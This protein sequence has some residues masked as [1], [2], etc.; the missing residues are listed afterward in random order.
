MHMHM[1]IPKLRKH[2]PKKRVR[3]VTRGGGSRSQLASLCMLDPPVQEEQLCMLDP[4][5]QRNRF[6]P[7]LALPSKSAWFLGCHPKLRAHM[8]P[9]KRAR[10]AA[11]S[12]SSSSDPATATPK[13]TLSGGV[14][15]HSSLVTLWRDERLIDFAVCAEG[16][17]FKAHRV[18]LAS[19]SKYFLNLFES[20]MRDAADATRVKNI[21]EKGGLSPDN[22]KTMLNPTYAHTQGVSGAAGSRDFCFSMLSVITIALVVCCC[23]AYYIMPV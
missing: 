3:V 11:A 12:A 20:G 2:G 15:H 21:I 13:L 9:K 8:A 18:A 16:V 19:S 22:A 1:Q 14:P 23:G 17:E 6:W 5:E 4:P 7:I 10:T